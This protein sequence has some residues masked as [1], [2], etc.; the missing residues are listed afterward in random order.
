MATFVLIPGAGGVAWY[1]H[2]VEPLLQRAGHESVAID[3]PGNDEHAG[4]GAYADLV[5]AAMRDRDRVTLVAQSL[6]GFTA[7]LVCARARE[8]IQR[9]VFVNAMIPV[10]GETVGDWW[11]HTGAVEAR[12]RAAM[13][14]GYSVEFDVEAYFLHDVPKSVAEAGA[15]H[16]RAEADIVFREIASFDGWPDIPIHVVVG[17]DDRFF[18]ADLQRRIAADRLGKPVDEIPG[19]HLVALSRP[20]ELANLLCGYV[21]G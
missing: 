17:R 20:H 6:G 13:R 8:G 12:K 9:L 14:D 10:P 21:A 4:L 1:W 19:G 11:D 15:K 18:P 2:R 5:L 16:E 7:A 3:L